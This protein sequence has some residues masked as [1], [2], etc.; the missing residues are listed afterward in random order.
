[1]CG[2]YALSADLAAL[3][4]EFTA[5]IA[6]DGQSWEPEYNI[7]PTTWAP[8]VVQ[9]HDE[10]KE[11]LITPGRWGLLPPW[12]KDPAER[13]PLFNARS[14]TVSEKR[15]FAESYAKRRCL[16]PAS[17]YFEWL[18]QGRSKTPHYVTGADGC[19]LALAGIYAWWKKADEEW[20]PTYAVLTA[21]APP[22]LS[23]LHDRVPVMIDSASW[24]AWLDDSTPVDDVDSIV[25][26]SS[27]LMESQVSTGAL[28]CYPVSPLVGNARN[29][30]RHLIDRL[31]D[32]AGDNALFSVHKEDQSRG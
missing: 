2:R 18:T 29:H 32:Q 13:A 17:G 20:W 21:A 11:R 28:E 3:A 24:S 19:S 1:V 7:A 27:S 15:S 22:A 5:T 25:H 10:H 8:I 31:D 23:W 26:T 9:P 30:G 14:E 6:Q 12:T 16:V 4:T